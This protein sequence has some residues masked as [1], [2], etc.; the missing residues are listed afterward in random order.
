MPYLCQ[1][2]IIGLWIIIRPVWNV[3]PS[4]KKCILK[5]TLFIQTLILLPGV[6]CYDTHFFDKSTNI[7]F[8][9]LEVRLFGKMFHICIVYI[10]FQNLFICTTVNNEFYSLMDSISTF[11][12]MFSWYVFVYFSV[13]IL[14]FDDFFRGDCVEM[15]SR[16]I[17]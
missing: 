12:Q 4:N 14:V 6:V 10:R 7:I 5:W 1:I 16:E 13:N 17:C 3:Y 11:G 9:I 8:K 15:Q 2:L